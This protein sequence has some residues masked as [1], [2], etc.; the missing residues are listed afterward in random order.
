MNTEF[1][2]RK[3]AVTNATSTNER[4]RINNFLP[5]DTAVEGTFLVDGSG[6][7]T[8]TVHFPVR[9]INRPVFTS[10][11]EMHLDTNPVAGQFPTVSCVV[12]RWITEQHAGFSKM[13]FVG[14]ELL[15]VTTGPTS[16]RLWVHWRAS[17]KGIVNPA[18]EHSLTSD[19][20]T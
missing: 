2:K 3:M 14:A 6:E 5:T 8:K 13:Y 9:F 17:G 4:E 7:A 20:I 15:V 18:V 1:I 12:H 16:Q 10:G 11:G 19:S